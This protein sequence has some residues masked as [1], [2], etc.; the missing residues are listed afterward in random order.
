M[1]IARNKINPALILTAGG[2]WK[3]SRMVGPG[4]YQ[5]KIFK[6]EAGAARHGLAERA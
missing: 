6:T 4:G 2:E 5:A 3:P 1:F